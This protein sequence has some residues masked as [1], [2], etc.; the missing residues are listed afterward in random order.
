M[1]AFYLCERRYAISTSVATSNGEALAPFRCLPPVV[2]T[3][4]E[5]GAD[6][7]QQRGSVLKFITNLTFSVVHAS[8]TCL[9]IRQSFF[10]C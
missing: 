4:F 9:L 5:R 3:V 8:L 1:L 2:F 10:F 7:R 6:S